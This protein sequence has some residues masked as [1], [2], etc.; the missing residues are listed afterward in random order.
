LKKIKKIIIILLPINVQ[1]LSNK[2]KH[3][4]CCARSRE[5]ASFIYV[6]ERP[7]LTAQDDHRQPFAP[8][9]EYFYPDDIIKAKEGDSDDC[10]TKIL[11]GRMA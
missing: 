11:P 9:L 5:N 10:C 7:S 4:S 6:T 2:K 3:S 1:K 8:S